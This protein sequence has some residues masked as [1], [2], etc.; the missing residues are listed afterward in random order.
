MTSRGAVMADRYD[1]NDSVTVRVGLR[2]A[3][4]TRGVEPP[5]LQEGVT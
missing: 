5:P 1:G 2:L 4:K 3:A